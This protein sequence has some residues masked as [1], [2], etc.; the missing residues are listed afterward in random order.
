MRTPSTRNRV[1]ARDMLPADLVGAV[2]FFCRCSSAFVAAPA[3]VV[4]GGA[5]FH[6]RGGES[7]RSTERPP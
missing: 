1:L 6:S 2:A 5:Y 7:N 4:D 3:I